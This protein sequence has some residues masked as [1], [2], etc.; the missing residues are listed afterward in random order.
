MATKRVVDLVFLVDVTGSMRPCIDGLKD[1]IDKFF[2][3]LT[4]EEGNKC[5]IK[6]W[7]AKVVGY[8]DVDFDKDSWFVDNPFVRTPGEIHDQLQ[9]LTAKGGGDEPESLLDALLTI[10][11]MGEAGI[12]D[13]DDAN[14]WRPRHAAA[15]A[16]IV[17][18]DATYHKEAML[19]KYSGCT[20][21][22]VARKIAEQRIILEI[23]TPVH[24]ADGKVAQEDFEKC[25]EELAMAD[26]AE[27]CPLFSEQGEAFS[28][29]EIPAH[30]DVFQKFVEQL[31]KTLSATVAPP[32]L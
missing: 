13:G 25:Y 18:T 7:R 32:E 2:A 28:F 11:D 14:K 6:D 24:P 5:S 8:R 29:G 1:S 9:A 20:F 12:Q 22:D 19:E 31:A 15:R 16:V 23:V 30:M 21:Q 26:K 4:D 27:Y 10:A 3:H 17:F